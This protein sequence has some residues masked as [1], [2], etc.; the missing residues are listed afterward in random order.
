MNPTTEEIELLYN[1]FK[2]IE[3]SDLLEKQKKYHLFKHLMSHV[4]WCYR[5]TGIT[6]DALICL[7]KNNFDKPKGKIHRGHRV[8]L[9][10]TYKYLKNNN[11]NKDKWWEYFWNNDKTVLMTT[12]ENSNKKN[13]QISDLYL[14]DYKKGLFKD[15]GNISYKHERKEK[16]FLKKLYKEKFN[17]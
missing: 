14:I 15:T 12:D 7:K 9:S 11:L 2:K 17:I 10:Q 4:E 1:L 13:K 16:E 3:N 5:V 8:N 6:R